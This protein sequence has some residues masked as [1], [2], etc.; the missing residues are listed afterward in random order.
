[1]SPEI[2]KGEDEPIP[3]VGDLLKDIQDKEFVFG[4]Y[5]F[6]LESDP[7]KIGHAAEAYDI[8]LKKS[9]V[10]GSKDAVEAGIRTGVG[11]TILLKTDSETKRNSTECIMGKEVPTV[12]SS[13]GLE[14]KINL[15][16]L[17]AA[18]FPPTFSKKRHAPYPSPGSMN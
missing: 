3:G 6:V 2:I 15:A 14:T 13:K 8:D 5:L 17:W 11:Q 16:T 18:H 10:I 12:S 4:R 7:E 1:V 9:I